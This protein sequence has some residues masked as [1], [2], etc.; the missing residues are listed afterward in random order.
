MVVI[1]PNSFI[2]LPK[3]Y[4]KNVKLF[5]IKQS[6]NKL[7]LTKEPN[8]NNGINISHYYWYIND[9]PTYFNIIEFSMLNNDVIFFKPHNISKL[10]KAEFQMEFNISDYNPNVR[11][12]W[13]EKVNPYMLL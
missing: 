12:K 2:V 7:N 5:S 10:F 4:K 3:I 1:S 6:D 13:E 11:D 9:V 8:I